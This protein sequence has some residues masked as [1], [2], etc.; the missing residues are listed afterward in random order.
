ME[1]AM[2]VAASARAKNA[3][4]PRPRQ[5]SLLS[6]LTLLLMLLL[7]GAAWSQKRILPID[8]PPIDPD[9]GYIET[10]VAQG[11]GWRLVQSSGVIDD[12]AQ[13]F[14]ERV[15]MIDGAH[16]LADVPLPQT[17]KDALINDL[18]ASPE[19]EAASFSISQRVADEIAISEALG[20]PTDALIALAEPDDGGLDLS[21]GGAKHLA[22]GSCGDR[23]ITRG[24]HF[25]IAAPLSG[26]FNISGGF[27]GNVSLTGTANVNADGEIKITLKRTKIL[28]VLCVPY[29]VKFRH[30][31]VWGT[32]SVEQGATV[33][34]TIN[35]ANPEAREWPIAKPHLFS[36][37]FMAGPLPVHIGF[38]LPITAGFDQ[39]GITGSVTGAVTYSGRRTL[40]GTLDYYCTP[41]SCGG[42]SNFDTT[43][44][45][46]QPVT[47]SVSGRFQPNIY[48]QVAVRGYLYGEGFAYAQVGVRPY[49]RAD[50]WGYYG[51]NCGD[52]DGDGFF[53]TVD[54]L[55]FDL[56]WQLYITAQA[57][58]FLTSEWRHTIWSSPRWHIG[59][60]DLLG[61]DGSSAL[62]PMLTGPAVVPIN[63]AQTYGARMRS[64]WP[65]TE[66]VD[67]ALNWG[68]GNTQ[69][70]NGPAATAIS[71]SHAWPAAGMPQLT[72]TALSD[73]HGRHLNA[74][75]TRT[76]DVSGT[77]F[78][79]ALSAYATAS[80][81]Y[82]SGSGEHCYRASRVNDGS[83]STALGGLNSWTNDNGQAMP[84]WVQLAWTGPTTFSRIE[85]YTTS[86]FELRDF[87]VQ[88]RRRL[89]FGIVVWVDLP[90]TPA[91]PTNNASTHLSYT[92]APVT[93]DA[94]R[95]L[96]RSGSAAQPGYARVNE[97]EVYP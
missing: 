59:F 6:L 7:S 26:N 74:N 13:P 71:A 60:W 25:N 1:T 68:D 89:P 77:P 61:G 29:G 75:T 57:D 44:L 36:I 11:E 81:T 62:S 28:W 2:N 88:A 40:S 42:F 43:D 15:F 37:N 50:L 73:A 92:M 65:Y 93:T 95:V 97:I 51:N 3:G 63:V 33:S 17:L 56:D 24:Q 91:F 83:N 48:A 30:A 80:S 41:S 49:L 27:T 39:G 16:G 10:V 55:T 67:Y 45:G 4:R 12:S 53:E 64:C 47:G 85:F 23:D 46:T 19:G 38:N 76:I 5:K 58:T 82:C 87:V 31:R 8:E 90:A 20:A 96:A 69:S 52:A 86:G 84:Q 66:N 72:L 9:P 78:N 94:I 34:G 35:Y 32:A 22:K 70:L 21:Q 18:A 79:L 54:A 14:S